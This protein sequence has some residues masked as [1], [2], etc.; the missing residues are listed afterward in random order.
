MGT[1]DGPFMTTVSLALA[2]DAAAA[3]EGADETAA[4]VERLVERLRA[5]GIES[6]VLPG[7]ANQL[8]GL[9]AVLDEV[10]HCLNRGVLKP[11]LTAKLTTIC[12]VYIF[13]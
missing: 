5:C 10:T 11:Q 13:T 6:D 9:H 4:K 7:V 1:F 3:A 8:G 2:A 12:G